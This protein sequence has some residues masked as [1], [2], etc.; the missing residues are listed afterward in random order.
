MI[1][2]WVSHSAIDFKSFNLLISVRVRIGREWEKNRSGKRN[3]WRCL[4]SSR[5]QHSSQ[6]CGEG[7]TGEKFRV[8]VKIII[9]FRLKEIDVLWKIFL[10]IF[11]ALFESKYI[12]V[13]FILVMFNPCT[14]KSSFTRNCV[15]E[16]SFSI[17]VQCRKIITL[18]FLWNKFQ[19]ARSRH[20]YGQSGVPWKETREQSAFT[21]NKCWRVWSIC[22]IKKSFTGEQGIAGDRILYLNQPVDTNVIFWLT[23][24]SKVTTYW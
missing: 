19:G 7:N 11:V 23:G 1:D 21:Q 13:L 14:R 17:W 2:E 22:T 10:Y 8:N 5:S 24:T 16:T 9:I 4:R 15:T 12:F 6:N 20:C 3:L 18:R